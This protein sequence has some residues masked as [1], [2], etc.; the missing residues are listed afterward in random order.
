MPEEKK[1]RKKERKNEQ[2][3]YNIARSVFFLSFSVGRSREAILA[4]V[5]QQPILLL[6][7]SS[8]RKPAREPI[9]HSGL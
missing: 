5:L 1:G 8:P 4:F 6:S 9:Y 2:I 7:S 3:C